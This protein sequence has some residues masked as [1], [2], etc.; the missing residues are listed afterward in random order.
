MQNEVF[1]EPGSDTWMRKVI[2]QHQDTLR[3]SARVRQGMALSVQE[4][5]Y[6]GRSARYGYRIAR[7]TDDSGKSKPFLE[8]EPSQAEVVRSIFDLRDNGI[9][10]AEIAAHLN[11]NDIPPPRGSRWSRAMVARILE[12]SIYCGIYT[13]NRKHPER[14]REFPNSALE[15][16]SPELFLRVQEKRDAAQ[17]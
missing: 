8:I 12:D 5:M 13:M 15:I 10:E 16:V 7:K 11:N 3:Q 17:A 9:L 1:E 6:L 14:R 2:S 4:G